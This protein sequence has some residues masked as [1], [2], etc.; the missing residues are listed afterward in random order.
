MSHSLNGSDGPRRMAI[1]RSR[2]LVIDLMRLREQVPT[3]AHD[4]VCNLSV[5]SAARSKSSMRISWPM[6]FI[7]AYGLVALK[8]PQLRQIFMS[9]PWPHLY[10]HPYSVAT[11]VTYRD[12][13]GEPWL[14]WSRFI[15]P[16]Q[17]S[18]TE[19]QFEM[20]RYQT[21]PVQ[22]IFMRQWALSALPSLLR[23]AVWWWTEPARLS[24]RT[25]W[26][27]PNWSASCCSD[28]SPLPSRSFLRSL[29]SHQ[30]RH[31]RALSPRETPPSSLVGASGACKQSLRG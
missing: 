25:G 13:D 28:E 9:W 2:R 16:E 20:D 21:E 18:L 12:L 19:L 7:K 26:M 8:Y 1:P 29:S 10:Q 6:L 17:L 5:A 14:F 23:R 11:V 31:K 27:T 24:G 30:S 3:T 15:A 4:R 22:E